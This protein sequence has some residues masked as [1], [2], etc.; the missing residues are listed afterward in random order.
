MFIEIDELKTVMPR[1][2][3]AIITNSDEDTVQE[4]I[5]ESIS[6]VSN[7]L[8]QFYDVNAIFTTT[9]E[10]RDKT[11]MKHLKAIIKYE[12]YGIRDGITERVEKGHEEAMRWLEKVSKGEIRPNLPTPPVDDDRDGTFLSA[13]S[14][15]KYK[16]SW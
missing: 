8:Y 13:G 7:Y 15:P 4:I 16:T 1:E 5:D 14:K 2:V 3:V 9:G 10:D 12:L 6:V 11:V